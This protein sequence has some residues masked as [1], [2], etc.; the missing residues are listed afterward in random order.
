MDL[1]SAFGGG[2]NEVIGERLEICRLLSE[3]DPVNLEVYKQEI[4]EIVRRQVIT[5]RRQEIDQSRVHADVKSIKEWAEVELEES[6]DRYIT[7]LKTGLSK[8]PFKSDEL[9]TD[10]RNHTMII[11]DD[12]VNELLEYMV[13][14]IRKKYLSADMGLDR[15]IS[16]RIRHGELERTM[17]IPIQ[18]HGLITKKEVKFGPY[19]S[20]LFWLEKL[21]TSQENLIQIDKAFKKFSDDYDNLISKIANEW[22]QI[23][24]TEKPLGLFDFRFYD[25]DLQR[26]SNSVSST[27]ILPD[28][29]DL[30]IRYLDSV[31]II[32]LVNI[33]EQ[34]NIRGKKEA[35]D[36]LMALYGEVENLN[37]PAVDLQRS[38]SHAKTDLTTQFDKII[39]WFVPSTEGS[40]APYTIEDAISVAEAIIKEG[41]PNFRIN[42]FLKD[43]ET[44]SI[45]GQLP[46]FID[47]FINIFENVVKRSGLISPEADI[48]IETKV[49]SDTGYFI[50]KIKISN[51]LDSHIDIV[52]LN[53]TLDRIRTL[54]EN[55]TYSEYLAT[56]RNSGLLK[57][58]KSVNDFSVIGASIDPT[59]NFTVIDK[60]FVIDIAVPFKMFTLEEEIN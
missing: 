42:I 43:E 34:L 5:S 4:N 59:M 51:N 11:P 8:R 24:S 15:F 32:L 7:Y 53:K 52:A 49:F 26:V 44:Y 28:F 39:E 58:H 47:I 25:V 16:T 37:F 46:I 23:N 40:S 12:E 57:I 38:I 20:N 55:G 1:S 6:F 33:R 14:E 36:L 30:V 48:E 29:I 21:N 27:S 60:R 9:N 13:S 3:L 41:T 31:L 35:K 54:L 56:E 17:R 19:S 2:S 10:R 50:T 45:H 22:L 18:K